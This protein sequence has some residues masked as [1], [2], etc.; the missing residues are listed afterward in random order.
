[1]SSSRAASGCSPEGDTREKIMHTLLNHPR[2][3]AAAIA[4][5]L[6]LTTA[7]VRR[8]LSALIQD[9]LVETVT[10]TVV[11]GRGRPPALFRLTDVGR[12]NFGHAYDQ[13]AS[14][15]LEALLDFAGEAGLRLFALRRAKR[16]VGATQPPAVTAENPTQETLLAAAEQVAAS[17]SD[18]GYAA[19]VQHAGYGLQLCH[20]HCPIARIAQR[21]PI[22]CETEHEVIAA[23]LGTHIQPLATIADGHG[24]CT[25]NIPLPPATTT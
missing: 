25:T 3:T 23:T 6:H 21:Y 15:A 5:Q 13:L 14:E 9:G 8:H 22:F 10:P 1:M 20:H 4:E 19:T 17:L 12:A 7:G 16:I 2:S 24:V 18:N 11:E